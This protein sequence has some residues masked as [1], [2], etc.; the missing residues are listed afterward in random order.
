MTIARYLIRCART[1]RLIA[2]SHDPA[3][4]MRCAEGLRACLID[5]YLETGS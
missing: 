3:R 4:A 1:G 5:C 2:W